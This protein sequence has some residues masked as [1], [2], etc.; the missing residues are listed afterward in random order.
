LP[1]P[2]LLGPWI[3]PWIGRLSDG[4]WGRTRILAGTLGCAAVLMAMIPMKLPFAI[5]LL[6]L[7]LLLLVSTLV[8]TVSD[9]VASDTAASSSVVP[10]MTTYAMAV[11]VGAAIGP[12]LGYGLEALL[13][14]ASM[15]WVSALVLTFL[16]TTWMWMARSLQQ[17]DGRRSVPM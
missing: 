7:F 1:E 15:Y 5:W 16:T 4:R 3:S 6:L 8:T 12:T 11:D 10:V 14:T 9:S 2:W 17:V 13:G